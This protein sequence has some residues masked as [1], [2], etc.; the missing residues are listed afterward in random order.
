MACQSVMMADAAV[1][2][3]AAGTRHGGRATKGLILSGL[4]N[5]S[6]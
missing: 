4:N 5:D 6:Q 3:A 2:H 1:M